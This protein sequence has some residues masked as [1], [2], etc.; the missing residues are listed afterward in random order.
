MMGD[1]QTWR[2]RWTQ[3]ASTAQHR[4]WLAGLPA[5]VA[6]R[7]AV[8]LCPNFRVVIEASIGCGVDLMDVPAKLLSRVFLRGY[9]EAEYKHF[10]GQ[11]ESYRRWTYML[12]ALGE[13]D[14][15]VALESAMRA[16]LVKTLE[17]I[18]DRVAQ[19]EMEVG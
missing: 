10:R 11:H 12:S 1:T 2:E 17:A 8:A 4:E 14:A 15:R 16:A 13:H 7:D 9:R 5:D 18:D 6:P 3:A 19:M